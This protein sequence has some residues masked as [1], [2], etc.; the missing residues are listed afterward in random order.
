MLDT[1]YMLHTKERARICH[2]N[3]KETSLEVRPFWYYRFSLLIL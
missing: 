1:E 2:T 3:Q